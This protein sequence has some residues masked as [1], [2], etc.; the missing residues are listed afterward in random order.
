VP[1]LAEHVRSQP[2]RRP[3]AAT[4]DQ[5]GSELPLAQ[6]LVGRRVDPEDVPRVR[7]DTRAVEGVEKH[8]LGEVSLAE[9][10]AG[11]AAQ[12]R[13]GPVR[14]DQLLDELVRIETLPASQ[15]RER[16]MVIR[17]PLVQGRGADPEPALELGFVEGHP[18]EIHPVV[19]GQ[20]VVRGARRRERVVRV[21]ARRE[22]E[23]EQSY[24]ERRAQHRSA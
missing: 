15:L 21:C 6:A 8:V 2:A 4:G 12:Q 20:P 24:R 3:V 16:A 18:V 10:A 23:P 14:R 5:N 1:Q 9:Q 13:G 19:V 7:W 17:E 22:D 11:V